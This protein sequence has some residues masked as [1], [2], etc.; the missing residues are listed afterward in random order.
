MSYIDNSVSYA[1]YIKEEENQPVKIYRQS[2]EQR[3]KGTCQLLRMDGWG[4]YIWKDCES[5]PQGEETS[6]TLLLLTHE[7]PSPVF[8]TIRTKAGIFN[9]IELLC[10]VNYFQADDIRYCPVTLI[11]INGHLTNLQFVELETGTVDLIRSGIIEEIK[12]EDITIRIVSKE[13]AM[14][15]AELCG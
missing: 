12:Q 8:F 5:H 6:K 4:N 2:K 11:A 13:E 10:S 15:N 9:E 7:I 3:A 1:L 14:R